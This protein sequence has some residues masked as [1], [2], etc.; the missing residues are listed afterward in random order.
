VWI[1][2]GLV[3]LPTGDTRSASGATPIWPMPIGRTTSAANAD[4]V[5]GGE[6]WHGQDLDQHHIKG[7]S[8]FA[9]AL[10]RD[11]ID[12]MLSGDLDTGETIMR[13]Y[14]SAAVGF[15]K[16]ARQGDWDTPEEPHPRVRAA[17]QPAGP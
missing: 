12:A 15:E 13:D 11:C 17:R 10:L 8:K 4:R 7:D 5:E 16:L 3:T 9:E 14:I 6:Q 1:D 2:F